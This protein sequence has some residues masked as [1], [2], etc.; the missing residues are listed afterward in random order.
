MLYATRNGFCEASGVAMA[1]TG[2]FITLEGVDGCGKSTQADLLVDAIE[3]SGRTVVRL[4]EPGGTRLSEKIRLLVL[5]PRNDDMCDECELLLYEAARAQLVREVIEPALACGTVVV[6]DRFY[7][8]TLAYQAYGRGLSEGLVRTA[9]D[10]GRCG[11]QPDLTLVFDLDP[12]EALKRATF[13]GADR[14]EGEGMEFQKRVREGYLTLAREEPT[15]VRLID[16]LGTREVV[17]ARMLTAVRD[18]LGY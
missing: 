15:R 17:R 12:E 5:D 10:L 13:E 4:R 3:S 7:D 6:C 1:R 8:S 9:N 18:V 11:L 2:V 14:L 16:A